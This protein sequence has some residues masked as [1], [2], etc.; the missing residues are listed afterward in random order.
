MPAVDG[1]PEVLKECIGNRVYSEL[2]DD[3]FHSA[4]ERKGLLEIIA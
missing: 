2:S 3:E 4:I 1:V